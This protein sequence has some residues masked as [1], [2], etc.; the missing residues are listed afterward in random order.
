MK[1]RKRRNILHSIRLK[2]CICFRPRMRKK[3]SR[4]FSITRNLGNYLLVACVG[5]T[6]ELYVGSLGG[7]RL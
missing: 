4:D 1:L 5:R 6:G 7:Q 3:R 2:I